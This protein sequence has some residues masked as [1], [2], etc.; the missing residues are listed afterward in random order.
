[1]L[2]VVAVVD[3]DPVILDA[4]DQ[5][6]RSVGY[7]TEL[8]TSGE[9]YLANVATSAAACLVSDINLEGIS[10]I[11]LRRQLVADGV[12][13]PTILMSGDRNHAIE[14]AAIESGCVAFLQKPFPI[15]LLLAAIEAACAS[16]CRRLS[17]K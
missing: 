17:N 8:F 2:N 16:G 4:V 14:S 9:A 11:E 3:D 5:M 10:G 1:M 7:I 13:I 12:A 6:L 15:C